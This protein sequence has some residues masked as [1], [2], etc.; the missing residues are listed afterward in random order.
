MPADLIGGC[1]VDWKLAMEEERAA[2][3]RIVALLFALA[4]LAE[5]ARNRSRLARHFS[6]WFLRQA[7][8]VARDFVRGDGALPGLMP[9]ADD[10]P[11]E[12]MRLAQAFRALAVALRR[13]AHCLVLR[14]TTSSMGAN[15]HRSPTSWV[16]RQVHALLRVL[17]TV[18]LPARQRLDSS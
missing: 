5:S 13:Q 8:T 17:Q 1:V 2:L 7:E 10:R 6:L 9:V 15:D 4:N 14:R 16:S 12:A 11:A 18:A 3:K